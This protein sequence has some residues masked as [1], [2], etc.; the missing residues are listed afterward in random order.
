MKVEMR[1]DGNVGLGERMERIMK[2]QEREEDV[3]DL[4]WRDLYGMP[5]WFM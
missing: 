2:I 4:M 3:T 5:L 1:G